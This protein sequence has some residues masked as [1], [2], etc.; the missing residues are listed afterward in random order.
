[1]TR[2]RTALASLGLFA[3]LALLPANVSA[4]EDPPLDC[5]NAMS[6]SDMNQCAYQDFEAADKELNAVWKKAKAYM[7][8]QDEDLKEMSPELVGGVDA[9]MKAQRAWIDYRDG[10][11]E[12]YGFQ[13]RGGSMEPMLVDGCKT[14]L[15]K[16]RTKE[17]K[18]IYEGSN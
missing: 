6:Q 15:T 13:S 18:E 7:V 8:K 5:E 17:L 12:V 16:A 1:M 10:Q 11:C 3:C 14:D 9:L 4:Q 2:T